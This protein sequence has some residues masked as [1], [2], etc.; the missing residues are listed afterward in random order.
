MHKPLERFY[1]YLAK[2]MDRKTDKMDAKKKEREA[3]WKEIYPDWDPNW[4]FDRERDPVDKM[5]G[6]VLDAKNPYRFL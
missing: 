3:E 2:I 1:N 6:I 4:D 5:L